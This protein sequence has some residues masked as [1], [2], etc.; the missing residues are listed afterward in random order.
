MGAL[1]E[2][3][4]RLIDVAKEHGG[5]IVVSIFVNP[6]QFNSAADL[7]RYPRTLESDVEACTA[8]GAHTVFAPSAEEVYPWASDLS[9]GTEALRG[10]AHRPT[11][12][13]AGSAAEGLCGSTRPGHFDGVVTVVS[14][15][16]NMVQPDAAV[17]GDKD[18]QQATVIERMVRDLHFPVR[19][20]RAP[21]VRDR[22]G[23][24]LSSRNVLLSAEDRFRALYISKT[25]FKAE[26]LVRAGER[27]SAKLVAIS[28]ENLAKS[29]GLRIDYIELVDADSLAP[30]TGNLDR[31]AQLCIAAFAGDVRLIDNI[32]L[33]PT[34]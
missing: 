17:F 32:R 27:D 15:L 3:H 5:H 31:P 4:L 22:D 1:H 10:G 24:A 21:I 23:L 18:Y 8:R 34:R 20:I 14:I 29:Q 7:A 12:V 6:I 9:S 26:E 11:R 33:E 19:I 25:L 30:V 13:Q 28:A 2:G 16:F